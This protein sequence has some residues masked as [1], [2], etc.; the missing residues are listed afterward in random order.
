MDRDPVTCGVVQRSSSFRIKAPEED[1]PDEEVV[2]AK[3]V[4][5]SKCEGL[6]SRKRQEHYTVD[7]SC[8]RT[9]LLTLAP[10]PPQSPVC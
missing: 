9:D 5:P 3:E 8:S 1:S 7:Y 2:I 4:G 10:R 6:S